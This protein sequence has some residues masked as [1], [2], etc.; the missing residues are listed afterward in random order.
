VGFVEYFPSPSQL[1]FS[2][3]TPKGISSRWFLDSKSLASD[4]RVLE[5][6]L[7]VLQ[8]VNRKVEQVPLW[9]HVQYSHG[10]ECSAVCLKYGKGWI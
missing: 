9:M 7:A 5:R 3:G 1:Y 2:H 6:T 10:G 8:N 4:Q